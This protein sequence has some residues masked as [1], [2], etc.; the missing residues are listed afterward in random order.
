MN[1]H[2]KYVEHIILSTRYRFY[3]IK[4]NYD[5]KGGTNNIRENESSISSLLFRILFFLEDRETRS[6]LAQAFAYPFIKRLHRSPIHNR[7]SN[8]SRERLN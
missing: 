3:T 5:V 2:L 4:Y 8:G 6:P 1:K 7:K